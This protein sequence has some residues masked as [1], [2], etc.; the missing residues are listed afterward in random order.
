MNNKRL[1]TVLLV[2]VM[3]ITVAG[4]GAAGSNSKATYIAN[5]EEISV[6]VG[7][8]GNDLSGM[9]VSLDGTI[10]K[11]PM[12][13]QTLLDA[14]WTIPADIIDRVDPFSALTETSGCVVTKTEGETEKK[15]TNITLL[16]TAKEDKP[17]GDVPI[18]TMSIDRYDN[19]KLILPKGIIW[20]S[21]IEDVKAAYG[22]PTKETTTGTE[23]T[24]I[25]TLLMYEVAN[26]SVTIGFIT[27]KG[28]TKMSG[29]TFNYRAPSE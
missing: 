25:N 11:L 1:V 4:C 3:C 6:A 22:E 19:I 21:T 17:V 18:T 10:Y 24:F 12:K 5:E 29:V 26:G 14:G 13:M 20:T 7:Q 2:M 27:E 28:E 8:L 23:D 16:N 15:I 9:S